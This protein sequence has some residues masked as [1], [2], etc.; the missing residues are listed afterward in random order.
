MPPEPLAEA[1]RHVPDEVFWRDP[2]TRDAPDYNAIFAWYLR[3]RYDLH[4]PDDEVPIAD[5][6]DGKVANIST[7]QKSVATER[8]RREAGA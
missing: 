4:D 3:R 7:F 1:L 5:L 8:A 6:E 2:R